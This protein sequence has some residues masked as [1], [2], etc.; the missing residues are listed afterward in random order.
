MVTFTQVY[1]L[2][3]SVLAVVGGVLILLFRKDF[4]KRNARAFEYLYEKTHFGVFKHQAEKMD[5]AY[6]RTVSTIVAIGFVMLGLY[7]V[8]HNI[9]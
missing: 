8:I 1:Y 2:I 7:T 6:M 4:L 9:L 3:W 5:T